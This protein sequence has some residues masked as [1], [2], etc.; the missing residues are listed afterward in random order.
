MS[1]Q[2][3]LIHMLI[4]WF[5]IYFFLQSTCFKGWLVNLSFYL[6]DG[7]G[8]KAFM[9]IHSHVEGKQTAQEALKVVLIFERDYYSRTITLF[10]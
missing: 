1:L 3:I 4:K 10:V 5:L 9:E 8:T 6:W 2:I 7:G